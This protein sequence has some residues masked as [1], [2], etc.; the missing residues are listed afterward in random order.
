[1]LGIN[2][3]Q[4]LAAV[5]WLIA[6]GGG[7]L[8]GKGYITAEQLNTISANLPVI[9]PALI[10]IGGLVWGIIN[11]TDKN[12]VVAAAQVPGVKA[13]VVDTTPAT[14]ATAGVVAAAASDAASAAKIVPAS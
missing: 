1:M 12:I 5:R 14:P 6:F 11:R 8:V 9:I 13:V 10:S 7:I 4:V 3:E 2:K